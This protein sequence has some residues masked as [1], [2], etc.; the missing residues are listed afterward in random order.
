MHLLDVSDTLHLA[1]ITPRC[2]ELCRERFVEDEIQYHLIGPDGLGF[3]SEESID[4]IWSYDVFVHVNPVDADA[5]LADFA[6]VLRPGGRA[7]IHHPDRY[8]S[9]AERRAGFRSNLSASFFASLCR[10]HGLRVIEQDCTRAHKRG[11][12]ITVLERP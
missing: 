7:V 9:H 10:K 3:L 12:C 4:L 1:D 11:D 6:K 2:L 8:E 5:Y